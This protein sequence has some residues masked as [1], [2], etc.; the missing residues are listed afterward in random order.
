MTQHG[1]SKRF[2]DQVQGLGHK[3]IWWDPTSEN[4]PKNFDFASFGS[5]DEASEAHIL[6]M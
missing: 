5:Q 4:R 3:D 6:I 1:L 2:R